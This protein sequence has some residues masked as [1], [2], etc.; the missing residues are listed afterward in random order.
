MQKYCLP[1]AAHATLVPFPIT[2][3]VIGMVHSLVQYLCINPRLGYTRAVSSSNKPKYSSLSRSSM[4]GL[5]LQAADNS[6]TSRKAFSWAVSFAARQANARETKLEVVAKPS[7]WICMTT[8]WIVSSVISTE[9]S[10][11]C[12]F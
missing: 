5:L 6:L 12:D 10:F 9:S 3:L 2:T 8:L 11:P 1:L 7:M 4:V